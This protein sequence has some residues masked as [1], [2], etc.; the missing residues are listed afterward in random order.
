MKRRYEV[1]FE[2]VN[3]IMYEVSA[4]NPQEADAKAIRKWK[5]DNKEAPHS[6]VQAA[7][8]AQNLAKWSI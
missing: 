7:Q 5:R 1:Y 2:Q 8:P 3:Q 4:E 6:T